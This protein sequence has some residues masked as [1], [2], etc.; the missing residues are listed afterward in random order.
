MKRGKRFSKLFYFCRQFLDP[1]MGWNCLLHAMHLQSALKCG[2]QNFVIRT[3]SKPSS[4]MDNGGQ[5]DNSRYNIKIHANIKMTF[6]LVY[7]SLTLS[8]SVVFFCGW[9]LFRICLDLV[10]RLCITLN[11]SSECRFFS[12]I[13]F[14]CSNVCITVVIFEQ[15][16]NHN[17]YFKWFY[18]TTLTMIVHLVGSNNNTT[19]KH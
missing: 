16:N 7:H 9:I 19:D 13:L 1:F 11:Q 3:H 2:W 17:D 15:N 18:F 5:T 4:Q 6:I 12:V 14:W 8:F 10:S